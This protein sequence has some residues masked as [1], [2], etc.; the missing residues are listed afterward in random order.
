MAG[1]F[2]VPGCS[3]CGGAYP[4][5]SCDPDLTGVL[6]DTTGIELDSITFGYPDQA[7][8][9]ALLDNLS[10]LL[11][12]IDP[13][14]HPL[15]LGCYAYLVLDAGACESTDPVGYPHLIA[16]AE[17]SSGGV[18]LHFLVGFFASTDPGD[19]VQDRS[20]LN[21]ITVLDQHDAVITQYECV[22]PH[23]L[24]TFF[25]SVQWTGQT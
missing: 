21:Y 17:M 4:C 15:I 22:G 6:I 19:I 2:T 10:L 25:G 7:D 16:L 8:C 1:R 14:T 13:A 20:T 11:T 9:Y 18:D 12:M 5:D 23:T 3:C 24:S